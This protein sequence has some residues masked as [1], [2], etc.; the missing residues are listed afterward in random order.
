[1]GTAAIAVVV[2]GVPLAFLLLLLKAAWKLMP[3]E[4]LE[5]PSWDFRDNG[6]PDDGDFASDREPRRPVIPT[7]SRALALALPIREPSDE[8]TPISLRDQ[9]QDGSNPGHRLAG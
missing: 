7:G 1:V 3:H 6:P 9:S 5:V 2:F 4:R 8:Q